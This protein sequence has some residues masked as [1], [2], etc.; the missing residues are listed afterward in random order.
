VLSLILSEVI[1]NDLDVIG[2]GV[3]APDS[4]TYARAVEVLRKYGIFDR[5]PPPYEAGLTARTSPRDAESR[6]SAF[7][8]TVNLIVGSS[9]LAL[10]PLPSVPA[11]WVT[12][13]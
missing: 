3:T 2:S 6:S 1:G 12:T 10:T 11:L 9:D 8:R 5:V 7:D 13:L 4:S